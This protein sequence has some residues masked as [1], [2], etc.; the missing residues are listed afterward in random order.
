MTD[1]SSTIF[2]HDLRVSTRIGIYS[3][4]AHMNQTVR[5]DLDIGAPS[6][7]PFASGRFEDALVG[8]R[9]A[10]PTELPTPKPS[11]EPSQKPTDMLLASDPGAGTAGDGAGAMTS[12]AI[13]VLLSALLILVSGWVIRRQRF[14][15]VRDR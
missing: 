13:W 7:K 1:A 8:F 10:E 9:A 14:A 15:E 6:P 12:W 5:L 11:P 2:I 3:W 4:E